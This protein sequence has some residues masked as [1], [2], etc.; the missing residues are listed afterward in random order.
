MLRTHLERRRAEAALRRSEARFRALIENAQDIITVLDAR[1][2]I[3][4]ESPAVQAVLGYRPEEL[5]GRSA[6][7]L[8]HPEDHRAV[9]ELFAL[10]AGLPGSTAA[11]EFRFRHR[12][13]SWRVLHG[14][15]KNCLDDPAVGGIVVNSRDVT[16]RKRAEE[17]LAK[18]RDALLQSEKL[19]AMSA[20]LAGVAHELNNPLAVV[21][22]RA[23]LL[24]QQLAG[25]PLEAPAGKLAQAAERCARIVKNFLALARQHPPERQAVHLNQVVQEALELMAYALRVDNV[26]V[27]LD[28][29]PELPAL[30]ADPHQLHQVVV[31][32][33]S[34][35]HHAMRERPLPHPRRLTLRTRPDGERVTL[36]VGDTGPGVPPEVRPR[37]FEPFFTTKPV[38]HGTGLGLSLC[39]GIV[40]SHGGRITLESEPGSGATFRVELPIQAAPPGAGGGAGAPAG[41]L[42]QDRRILVV[43]DEVEVARLIADLLERE[44]QRVETASDGRTALEKLRAAPFDLIV[45]DLKMPELDG[46]GL[47]REVA[48]LRPALARRM[49]FLTGDTL[50]PDVQRFLED[51]RALWVRKPFA[52]DDLRRVVGEAL[53]AA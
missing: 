10:K 43:D 5:L 37:L 6:F 20:L 9:L 25:T 53:R 16:E 27:V 31:N 14:T 8:L 39:R 48:R 52:P 4:Y 12:D 22:G 33:I 18:Q 15:A 51:A 32:L 1:G 26:E 35:A 44:G 45:S 40:E 38:G 24:G 7:E 46:P 19:A 29:S 36:E 21:V 23:A 11:A 13:G 34:N 30:W 2:V 28:L 47:Y 3:L 50:G 41:P 49:V 42:P 17:E